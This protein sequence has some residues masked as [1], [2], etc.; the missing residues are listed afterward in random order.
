MLL[1][2]EH[3]VAPSIA[4]H[5]QTAIAVQAS[6][7]YVSPCGQLRISKEAFFRGREKQAEGGE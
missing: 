7:F 2:L 3:Q 4:P 6:P 5:D 1:S